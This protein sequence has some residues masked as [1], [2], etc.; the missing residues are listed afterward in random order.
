MAGVDFRPQPSQ[1]D[2]VVTGEG[3]GTP[4]R[5]HCDGNRAE[6]CDYQDQE[7]Q[8][9]PASGRVHDNPKDVRQG[10]LDWRVEY[11]FQGRHRGADGQDKE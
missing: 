1:G 10:L 11:I 5:S 9:K 6:Q 7:G 2:G 3:P 8:A 4:R